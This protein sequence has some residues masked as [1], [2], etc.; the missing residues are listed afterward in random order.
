MSLQHG[1]KTW[2]IFAATCESGP[3]TLRHSGHRGIAINAY[4]FDGGLFSAMMRRLTARDK[5]Y[6]RSGVDLGDNAMILQ[7]T[8]WSV[9]MKCKSHS[10][11]NAIKWSVM[12]MA[13][14]I[15]RKDPRIV[16]ESLRNGSSQLLGHISAFV[17]SRLAFAHNRSMPLAERERFWKAFDVEPHFIDELCAIDPWWDGRDLYV[18]AMFEKDEDIFGR[19]SRL[20]VYFMRW[21]GFSETRWGK[22]CRSAR[23]VI[24]VVVVGL[25]G[26]VE[27]VKADPA[28]SLFDIGGY[29]RATPSVRKYFA[30][31]AF[32]GLPAESLVMELFEDDRLLK[33]GRG[34]SMLC[35]RLAHVF[36]GP[37][38]VFCL[39]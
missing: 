3:G 19:A 36:L 35:D 37:R 26:L 5:T 30:V 16:V 21:M 31:I 13:S 10:C 38:C 15:D 17:S 11:S 2:S 12:L 20:M 27:I 24:R 6:Y 8:D 28:V 1:Q 9:F 25:D 22:A 32:A 18:D 23:F 33:R 4:L 29:D 39:S 34:G 14:A 7:I